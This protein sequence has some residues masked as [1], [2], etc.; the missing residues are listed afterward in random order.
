MRNPHN[1]FADFQA[2]L[3]LYERSGALIGFLVDRRASIV[4][5]GKSNA[6]LP[7]L[8]ESLAVDMYEYSIIDDVDV[9][10][11]LAWL[12]DLT[13]AGYSAAAHSAFTTGSQDNPDVHKPQP[14]RRQLQPAVDVAKPSYLLVVAV[15]S[16]RPDRRLAIRNSWLTWGDD[17]VMVRFFTERDDENS[18]DAD[19]TNAALA[20]EID[21][22]GDVVVMEME[23]G[24]NFA[25]KMLWAMRW[26]KDRY[27]FDFFLRLDDDYFLCLNRLLGELEANRERL[28]LEAPLLYGGFR[29]CEATKT[30]V[31]EAYMLLSTG[32]VDRVLSTA[33]LMCGAHAGLTA[34][35][36]FAEHHQGNV[37]ND[38]RWFFDSRLD[39]QGIW[40][41]E[42]Q[43]GGLSNSDYRQVCERHIGVHH[44]Y[45]EDM[46][47]LWSAAKDNPGPQPGETKSAEKGS[48]D[49]A[50][51]TC[52][53]VRT[54]VTDAAFQK[55]HAQLCKSFKPADE[56]LHCGE[57]GC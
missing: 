40:W 17:R 35:W 47:S 56:R 36:W 26:L 15:V 6:P 29:Y 45:A 34:G 3:E 18:P 16:I 41:L 14:A 44:T 25:A 32:L 43:R 2:E 27:A 12:Q 11:T 10:L 8:I 39:H 31:D 22:F 53:S 7:E 19:A 38:V 21:A 46:G 55:D 30:R 1:N 57:E 48:F 42:V 13:D 5:A 24:M 51:D 9:A 54:G 20:A 33:G 49:Y 50:A 28:M 52:K 4:A 23:R 37:D